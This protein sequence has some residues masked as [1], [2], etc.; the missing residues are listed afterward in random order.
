MPKLASFNSAAAGNIVPVLGWY[1][2]DGIDYGDNLPPA[3]NL[4]PVADSIWTNTA[5]RTTGAYSVDK[6]QSP[7]VI[8]LTPP[9]SA[10]QQ[11]AAAQALQIAKLRMACDAW[12]TG[13]YVSSALGAP[14]TYPSTRD[15][16]INMLGSVADAQ[17]S[18]PADWTTPFWCVDANGVWAM[19]EHTAEQIQQAGS[20]GKAF[21]VVAQQ[22]L[23]GLVPQV[24][25]AT[26]VAA[27]QAISW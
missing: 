6:S 3:S 20:D 11:L 14:H 1:D 13:G 5:A 27:V 25:A 10:A 23:V 9:P 22:K 7:P 24:L 21:I 15:D 12:I 4:T 2:T 26:T 17:L 16:Q 19:A 18:H 8:V